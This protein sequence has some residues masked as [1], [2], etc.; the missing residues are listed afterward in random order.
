MWIECEGI[1]NELCESREI[2]KHKINYI[3]SMKVI[4][5]GTDYILSMMHKKK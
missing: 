4:L 5:E 3:L 1:P 2:K